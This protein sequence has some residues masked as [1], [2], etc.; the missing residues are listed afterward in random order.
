[1][2]DTRRVHRISKLKSN[3]LDTYT[4]SYSNSK[5]SSSKS[6]SYFNKLSSSVI[7]ATTA[8]TKK[9]QVLIGRLSRSNSRSPPLSYRNRQSRSTSRGRTVNVKSSLSPSIHGF[10]GRNRTTLIIKTPRSPSPRRSRTPPATHRSREKTW[11]KSRSRSRSKDDDS[12][13]SKTKSK[14]K[15]NFNFIIRIKQGCF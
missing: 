10:A 2:S 14:T 13:F 9:R 7:T 15:S 3:E 4:D 8:T 1:M 12:K 6:S 11:S 5:S